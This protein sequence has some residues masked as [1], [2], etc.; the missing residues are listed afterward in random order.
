PLLLESGHRGA[1]TLAVRTPGTFSDQFVDHLSITA[2]KAVVTVSPAFRGWSP[3]PTPEDTGRPTP[4]A[5]FVPDN[6]DPVLRGIS[7]KLAA[8]REKIEDRELCQLL[9]DIEVDVFRA[10]QAQLRE[11][12]TKRMTSEST[13]DQLHL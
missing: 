6:I 11:P 2:R 12:V 13:S 1:L 7:A 8:I 4:T 9:G 5:R 10:A 3:T